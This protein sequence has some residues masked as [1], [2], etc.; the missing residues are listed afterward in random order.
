MAKSWQIFV[1]VIAFL[2]GLPVC[3][4]SQ[5]RVPMTP[6]APTPQAQK[7][8]SEVHVISTSIVTIGDRQLRM[9]FVEP[10]GLADPIDGDRVAVHF[11]DDIFLDV[12]KMSGFMLKTARDGRIYWG[13]K[14]HALTRLRIK[15]F[16]SSTD[17]ELV[18]SYVKE[19]AGHELAHAVT[20]RMLEQEDWKEPMERFLNANGLT[21]TAVRFHVAAETSGLLGQL[22]SSDHP[23]ATLAFL[24]LL[25]AYPVRQEAQGVEFSY[26]GVLT[27]HW[28]LDKLGY[29]EFLRQKELSIIS[30]EE[31]LQ[32]FRETFDDMYSHGIYEM[33]PHFSWTMDFIRGLK[34]AD[35]IKTAKKLHERLFGPLPELMVT[36]DASLKDYLARLVGKGEARLIYGFGGET[37]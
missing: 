32:D 27:S 29:K 1:I 12:K 33:G 3:L 20:N 13:H 31:D 34:N 30:T 25:A 11:G 24:S 14:E 8:L 21:T 6:G 10:K 26:A 5:D 7:M 19:M 9:H 23:R 37:L 16:A 17:L 36:I 22:I 15:E 4:Q 2:F 28:I 35:I 18:L